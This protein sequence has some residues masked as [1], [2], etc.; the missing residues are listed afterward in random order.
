MIIKN[1]KELIQRVIIN[2]I[3]L[4]LLITTSPV[5]SLCWLL[6]PTV[7]FLWKRKY[8]DIRKIWVFTLVSWYFIFTTCLAETTILIGFEHTNP[9]INY[10]LNNIDDL[11][12]KNLCFQT[13]IIFDVLSE[14]VGLSFYFPSLFK[15]NIF[16]F[17]LA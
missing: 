15:S 1:P 3:S 8:I 5:L 17:F 11:V 10:M 6:V 7:Y 2:I 16:K 9:L 14:K 4:F 12:F 13:V